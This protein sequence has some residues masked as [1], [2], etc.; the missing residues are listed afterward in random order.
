[1][2]LFSCIYTEL[3]FILKCQ[4]H[5]LVFHLF[6][7]T[8]C[9]LQ[10][11]FEIFSVFISNVCIQ[12]IQQNFTVWTPL[13]VWPAAYHAD[14]VNAERYGISDESL[15]IF[16]YLYK[17]VYVTILLHSNFLLRWGEQPL[18]LWLAR[19]TKLYQQPLLVLM[20][21]TATIN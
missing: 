1:M 3:P 13:Q 17:G 20:A 10:V 16:N 5:L 11:C 9:I 8:A 12:M 18:Q 14:S 2:T 6:T 4:M 19:R 21:P 7:F 15:T